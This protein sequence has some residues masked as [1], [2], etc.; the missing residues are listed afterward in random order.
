MRASGLR[1]LVAVVVEVVEELKV[2]AG[3]EERDERRLRC[4]LRK[5]GVMVVRVRCTR[6][7]LGLCLQRKGDRRGRAC[8]SRDLLDDILGAREHN[9][10][11]SFTTR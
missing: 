3:E 7:R 1:G 4:G 8:Q 10:G 6:R 11:R 5:C 2:V 9:L